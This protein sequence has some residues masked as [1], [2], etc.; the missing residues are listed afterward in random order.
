[1]VGVSLVRVPLLVFGLPPLFPTPMLLP[2]MVVIW[3]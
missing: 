1:M 2:N 3:G